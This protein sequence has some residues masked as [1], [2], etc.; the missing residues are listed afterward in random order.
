M[1]PKPVINSILADAHTFTL[2]LWK[3]F[4][5]PYCKFWPDSS[6]SA[7]TLAAT[8]MQEEFNELVGAATPVEE[9][10]AFCDLL[11]VT[12]GAMHSVGY[13]RALI[14]TPFSNDNYTGPLA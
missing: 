13:E 1:H 6:Y 7:R 5:L 2:V 3:A 10:D 9:L 11:Y 4:K 8:L 14:L 12:A